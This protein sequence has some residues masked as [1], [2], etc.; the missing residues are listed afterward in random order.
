MTVYGKRFTLL[1]LLPILL[2]SQRMNN[3]EL[4][5]VGKKV[6]YYNKNIIIGDAHSHELSFRVSNYSNVIIAITDLLGNEIRRVP[7]GLLD[8]GNYSFRWDMMSKDGIYLPSDLY[9]IKV[10][11]NRK[12]T[13]TETVYVPV[14]YTYLHYSD[15]LASE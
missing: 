4:P 11:E 8:K 10:Y 6:L 1:I 7:M 14:F 12:H 15:D 2:F 13:S 3:S 9:N 5:F